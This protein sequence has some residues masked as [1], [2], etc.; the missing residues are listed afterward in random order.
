MSLV[1]KNPA[2]SL[3]SCKQM[4]WRKKMNPWQ[5]PCAEHSSDLSSHLG[6]WKRSIWHPPQLLWFELGAFRLP[7]TTIV[8]LFLLNGIQA[9]SCNIVL[10]TAS[11][12]RCQ[13]P[14]E[15][16]HFDHL[17]IQNDVKFM[18]QNASGTQVVIKL[19]LRSK[20]LAITARNLCFCKEIIC[21]VKHYVPIL[22]TPFLVKNTFCGFK[23]L[24][25]WK[26][27]SRWRP[28][29][30]FS[31]LKRTCAAGVFGNS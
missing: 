8:P 28:L 12:L 11:A 15:H 7:L 25:K 14:K 5:C 30:K 9:H 27:M 4:R 16:L 2:K 1:N 26:H 29:T 6:A 19:F 31:G 22:T 18:K 20:V 23:S 3:S 17:V 13:T 10:Y 24:P 21:H